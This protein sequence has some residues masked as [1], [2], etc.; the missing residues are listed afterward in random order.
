MISML[1][2]EE[3]KAEREVSEK[4]RKPQ[5]K[6][7]LS[8]NLSKD[9]FSTERPTRIELDILLELKSGKNYQLTFH[10]KYSRL[11]LSTELSTL[12]TSKIFPIFP[13]F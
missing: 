7:H 5:L 1:T 13:I 6:V 12:S 9:K 8:K 11:T 4:D 2:S 3:K 10:T